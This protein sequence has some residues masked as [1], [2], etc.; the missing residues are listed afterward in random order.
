MKTCVIKF[1]KDRGHHYLSCYQ[2]KNKATA[3]GHK[4]KNAS[5][6]S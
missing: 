5:N 2:S 6:R 1:S 4:P 3:R